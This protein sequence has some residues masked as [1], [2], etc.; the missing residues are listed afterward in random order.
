MM[1][2]AALR[3]WTSVMHSET[4]RVEA[5][6]SILRGYAATNEAEFFAVATEAFF[7]RPVQLREKHAALYGLL[8]ETYGQDPASAR[9]SMPP[10]I[11]KEPA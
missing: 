10:R 9:A 7:E 3:P 1:P 4:T 5:R 8:E 2:W 11:E 6:R